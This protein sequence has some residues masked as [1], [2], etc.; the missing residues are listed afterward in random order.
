M[1]SRMPSLM[2]GWRGLF[3]QTP[4]T[5]MRWLLLAT[6]EISTWCPSSLQSPMRRSTWRLNNWATPMPLHWKVSSWNTNTFIHFKV[7]RVTSDLLYFFTPIKASNMNKPFLGC[8]LQFVRRTGI[9]CSTTFLH[10][11]F[12]NRQRFWCARF[13]IY[14][15]R[16]FY[17]FVGSPCGVPALFTGTKEKWLWTTS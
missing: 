10:F 11:S 3:L 14:I 8:S 17:R 16:S 15:G 9:Y 4:P 5:Q 12:R 13:G 6:T 1:H 2:S 7:K